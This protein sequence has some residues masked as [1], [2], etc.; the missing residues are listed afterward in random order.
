[1]STSSLTAVG[2]LASILVLIMLLATRRARSP[3]V[4]DPPK[5]P[6]VSTQL[7][8]V[9]DDAVNYPRKCSLV[10]TQLVV[11]DDVDRRVNDDDLTPP[12]FRYP[13]DYYPRPPLVTVTNIPTR[14]LPDTFS[15]LGNLYREF[16]NKV[17]RLY[18]RRRYD[19]VWD[20]YAILHNEADAIKVNIKTK[21]DKE[22]LDGDEVSIPMFEHN[23]SFRVYL[24]KKD[25][26]AYSP[27]IY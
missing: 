8:T 7:D 15:Y 17:M 12:V 6:L 24:H 2:S 3:P 1:M 10:P 26:F 22:L 23:G 18:G 5:C 14:G 13:R 20:Y 4:S 21:N 16:D 19:D 25:E 27:Y 9:N 11:P